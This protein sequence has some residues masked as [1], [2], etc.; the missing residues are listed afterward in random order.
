MVCMGLG[1]KLAIATPRTQNKLAVFELP[2]F[3]QECKLEMFSK[4]SYF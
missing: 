1:V 4:V 2:R 3:K